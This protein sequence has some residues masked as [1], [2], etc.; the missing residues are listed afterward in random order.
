MPI[1][2]D[3]SNQNVNSLMTINPKNSYLAK[4]APNWSKGVLEAK[5]PNSTPPGRVRLISPVELP[6]PNSL[7]YNKRYN[8]HTQRQE[9]TEI[10]DALRTEAIVSQCTNKYTDLV[11]KMGYTLKATNNEA[12]AYL[13]ARLY[14]I[15]MVTGKSF[16]ALIKEISRDFITYGNAYLVKQRI[17]Q[18]VTVYGKDL[19]PA[20]GLHGKPEIG[21]VGGYFRVDPKTMH[22]NFDQR[23]GRHKSWQQ[24]ASEDKGKQFSLEEVIHF[25]YQ[26]QAGEILGISLHS[27]VLGDIR[28]LRNIEEYYIKLFY[29][30]LFPV[31]HHEVPAI[32]EDNYGT[33]DDVLNAVQ[34]YAGSAPDGILVTPPGHKLSVVGAQGHSLDGKPFCEYMTKRVLMGEGIAPAIMGLDSS[35]AA[36]S[37]VLTTQMHDRV[38]SIQQD[39]EFVI[40][41]YIITELLLEGG[42]NPLKDP[43]DRI[44]LEFD[45]VEQEA[46][47]RTENH[48]ANLYTNKVL[49]ENEVRSAARKN[50]L[51]EKDRKNKTHHVDALPQHHAEIDKETAANK[52]LATHQMFIDKTLATH[53]HHL[54][55]RFAQK[56]AEITPASETV[57]NTRKSANGASR[58]TTTKKV[59]SPGA[60]RGSS[61]GPANTIA[62]KDNPSNKYG[63][64]GAPRAS[65]QPA[66]G[67]ASKRK[68]KSSSISPS[69]KG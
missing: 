41:Q 66:A 27:P 55:V 47:I 3:N 38:K 62:N 26:V 49:T 39:L 45:E 65:S 51:T 25:A 4:M 32:G 57:T 30:H 34:A 1:Y 44:Y 60:P 69:V 28:A 14:L 18:D 21:I 8:I 42:F 31:M 24:K 35:S 40:N 68:A 19:K 37:D 5:V 22:P 48:A 13:E 10:Y 29:K 16:A 56:Q 58:T 64:R 23:N 11:N 61:N 12:H 6:T 17:K 20:V 36:T 52:D 33:E 46:Q 63:S 43:N 2:Q 9:D 15:S 59:G 53:N 67:M 7:R 50:P 54:D